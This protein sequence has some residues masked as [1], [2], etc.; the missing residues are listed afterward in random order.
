MSVAVST[1]ELFF[2]WLGATVAVAGLPMYARNA[3][4]DRRFWSD[5]LR[6]PSWA[7]RSTVVFSVV[8]AIL[9]TLQALAATRMRVFGPWQSGVNLGALVVY[10]I[11]Q[12]VLA[13]YTFLLFSLRSLWAS[14]ISVALSLVLAIIETVFAFRLDT[15]S[16]IVFVILDIWLVYALALSISI[17]V[18]TNGE[19]VVRSGA[20]TQIVC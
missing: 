5:V 20:R 1:I 2:Y 12:F 17:W 8:W 16:G 18:L 19:K 14:T 6:K 4:R 7:P 15:L 11:L 13:S 3:N 10:V 9:Y